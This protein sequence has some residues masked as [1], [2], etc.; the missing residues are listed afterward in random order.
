MKGDSHVPHPFSRLAAGLIFAAALTLP[1]TVAV[2]EGE[3]WENAPLADGGLFSTPQPTCNEHD[4]ALKHLEEKY[5]EKTVGIGVTSTGG[6][7]ELLTSD[8]G[9]TWTIIL[10][11]P[12]GMTCMI[13]DGEGWRGMERR[14]TP[15]EPR[16]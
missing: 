13:A 1:T 11:T 4:K 14:D 15:T 3:W 7:L 2:A 5:Q 8:G 9:K 6:L 12:K 16:V 10:T